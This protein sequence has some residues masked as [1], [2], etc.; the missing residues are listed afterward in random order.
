MLAVILNVAKNLRR[1]PFQESIFWINVFGEGSESKNNDF[2][3]QGVK[4]M[5]LSKRERRIAIVTI[6]VLMIFVFDRFILSPVMD[7]R[8]KVL[9]QKEDLIREMGKAS[10]LFKQKGKVSAKYNEMISGGLNSDA[11]ITESEILNA[12]R[13]WSQDYGLSLSSV[14]PERNKSGEEMRE[15]IFNLACSGDMTSLSRFL[16][17]VETSTLPVKITEIQLGS[18]SDNGREMSLQL[19]LSALYLAENAGSATALIKTSEGEH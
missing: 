14:K 5:V 18:N 9:S 12:I 19:K 4:R 17:R 13:A 7:A 11:S 10:G 3:I 1:Q 6:A 2:Y 16:W 8:D 15:I